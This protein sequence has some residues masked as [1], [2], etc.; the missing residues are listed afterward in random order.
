MDRS[1]RSTGIPVLG[2]GISFGTLQV[3]S[4]SRDLDEYHGVHIVG[5]H[6]MECNRQNHIV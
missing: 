1:R 4:N 2:D 5:I 6:T 3:S